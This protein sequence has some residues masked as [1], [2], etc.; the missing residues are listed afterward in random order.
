MADFTEVAGLASLPFP[1]KPSP[2]TAQDCEQMRVGDGVQEAIERGAAPEC[3]GELRGQRVRVLLPLVMRRAP[4]TDVHR[5]RRAS[6]RLGPGT[7][8][9]V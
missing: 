3:V 9:V 5:V 8:S 1:R 6:R 2:P 7:A 4:M